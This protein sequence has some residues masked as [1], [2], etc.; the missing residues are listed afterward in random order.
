MDPVTL[1]LAITSA[2]AVIGPIA[3]RGAVALIQARKS[4]AGAS[5]ADVLGGESIKEGDG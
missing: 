4:K 1:I 2:A 5:V 3:F